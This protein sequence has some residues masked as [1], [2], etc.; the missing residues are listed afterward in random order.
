VPDLRVR[1]NMVIAASLEFSPLSKP[2]RAAVVELAR[3]ELLTPRGLRTL[4]PRDPDYRGRYEGDVHSRDAA[5]HQGTVWPWLLGPYADAWLTARGRGAASKRHLRELLDGFEPHLAERALGFVSEVFDG[6]APH[7]PGGAPAQA[8]SVA[9]LA[10]ARA[11]L[12]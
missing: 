8:W 12:G 7:R 2:Q 3:A 6:D 5:Y 10:R 9:E 1:P 4:S 11:A